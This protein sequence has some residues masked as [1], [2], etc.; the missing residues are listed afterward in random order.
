MTWTIEQKI[1]YLCRLPWTIVPGVGD[2]DG[3]R[4]LRVQELPSV[5]GSG[6]SD[7]ELESEFWDSMKATLAGLLHFGD[8]IP[9]PPRARQRRLPWEVSA[10][11]PVIPP[12]I[13]YRVRDATVA[14][15]RLEAVPQTARVETPEPAMM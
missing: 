11:T 5:V 7:G 2:A 1:A 15:A 8:P 4:T 13:T 9:L 3:E 12:A 10:V 6:L 14:S